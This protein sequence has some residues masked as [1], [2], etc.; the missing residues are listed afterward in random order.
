M[1]YVLI[2][3]VHIT[4]MSSGSTS[5]MTTAEFTTLESCTQA[6]ETAVKG[7]PTSRQQVSYV[8]VKKAK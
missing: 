6:G 1:L 3:L 2:L 4:T 5:A 8:C 7:L